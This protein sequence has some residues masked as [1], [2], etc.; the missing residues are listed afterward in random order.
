VTSEIKWIT[1]HVPENRG[2]VLIRI[3]E[4]GLHPVYH[5]FYDKG[6]HWTWPRKKRILERVFGWMN[7]EDAAAVLDNQT[8]VP[9]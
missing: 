7:L 4:H 1:D 2:T 3:K 9:K 6:W 8:P 5:A